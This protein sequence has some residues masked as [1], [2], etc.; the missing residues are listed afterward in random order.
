MSSP[1]P[2][3]VGRTRRRSLAGPVVLIV[4]GV[5]FLMGT[6]GVLHWY[7]LGRLFA[8]YWPLLIILWGVVKLIEHQQAQR[9]GTRASGISIGGVFL[10]CCLIVAGLISTQASRVNWSGLHDQIGWDDEDFGSLFGN[11]YSFTDQSSQ[12][13][14]A[15]GSLHV[16]SDRGDVNVVVSEG[17]QIKVDIAKK[18]H[19]ENQQDADKYNAGTKPQITIREKIVT[20]NANTQGAGEHGVAAD[21]TISIPRK[22]PV[23]ISTRHGDINVT[24]RDGSLDISSQRG[25]VMAEDINGSVSL[26]LQ[27]SSAKV[28]HVSGDVTVDGRVNDLTVSNVKGATRLTG[29]FMESVHL[30]QIGKA[31]TFKSSRT[32][33]EFAKLEGNLDLDS[34]DL[35]AT[36]A[37]GPGRLI[38]RSKDIHLDGM[39]GDLRL[40]D[41][42]GVVEVLV[43]KLGNLQI[44]NRNGDI[45]LALPPQA[46]F[47]MD[48]RARN[49]EIQSDFA[50]LKVENAHDQA[51]LA[52]TVGSGNVSVRLNNEHG[53]IEIHKGTVEALAPPPPAVPK[54]PKAL[55]PPREKPLA[56][57]EN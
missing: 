30:S 21:M 25:E 51:T 9:E 28:S 46:A 10:L 41:S 11:T 44:D 24:G 5:V 36:S 37:S 52:G 13:F 48:A 4:M 50:E 1:A 42:N 38:T 47:R 23:V 43:R 12:T 18:V 56:P 54:A 20:V 19:A 15:G 57:T 53:T 55:P 49:G 8:H 16:V 26:N 22:V 39:S 33:M 40:E 32:D 45:Q 29:E 27:H 17:N 35:R 6:M 2:G 34:G 14:P 7:M 3:P 31:V